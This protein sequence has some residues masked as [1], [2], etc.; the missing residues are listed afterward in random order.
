MCNSFCK[1]FHIS[2]DACFVSH[3]SAGVLCKVNATRLKSQIL[4]FFIPALAQNLLSTVLKLLLSKI[5]NR[6]WQRTCS[7]GLLNAL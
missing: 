7:D 3:I 1:F 6:F 2:D 5:K 4:F